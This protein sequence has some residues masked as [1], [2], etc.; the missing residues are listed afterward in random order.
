V[1]RK[2]G[3]RKAGEEAAGGRFAD[4]AFNGGNPVFGYRAA[5][6]VVDELDALAAFERLEFDAANAE[7]AVPAGLFL[8]LAFGVALPR[9]VSR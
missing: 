4:A 6:N 1:A 5:E 2:I 9:M 8:V 7:L 3:D